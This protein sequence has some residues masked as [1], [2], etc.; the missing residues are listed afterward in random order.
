MKIFNRNY[1]LA[2]LGLLL[3]LA[4]CDT[5]DEPIPAFIHIPSIEVQTDPST[6][7]SPSHGITHASIFLQDK[8]T[9]VTHPIGVVSLPATFPVLLEGEYNLNIDP[10]IRANGSILYLQGYPFYDRVVIPVNLEPN[11]ETTVEP[12][13]T[14]KSQT[15][16]EFIENFEGV[17][18]IFMD[19]RDEDPGT[20]IEISDEDVLDGDFSGKITLDTAHPV[21]AVSTNDAYTITFPEASR[22]F[23]E[24][25]DLTELLL[26]TLEEKFIIILQAGIPKPD[27]QF[28]LN[29]AHIYLDN[30]KLVHF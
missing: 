12:V 10:A 21:I 28:T 17:E 1:P 30:I 4:S 6:Q 15:K 9:L 13:T 29:E 27:G 20:F 11:V 26:A 2:G 14:Y 23:L 18:H 19:D 8:N 24:Y 16:F 3:F 7:G 25:L 22:V 5:E